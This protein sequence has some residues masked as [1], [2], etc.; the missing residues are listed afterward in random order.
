MVVVD[1]SSGAIP[2]G[3]CDFS[4]KLPPSC[5]CLRIFVSQSTF[6]FSF[7]LGL[8]TLRCGASPSMT[9]F[10][11]LLVGEKRRLLE[12]FMSGDRSKLAFT[13]SDNG[14]VR[15]CLIGEVGS[16]EVISVDSS[17]MICR[18]FVISRH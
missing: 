7:R 18:P 5:F 12:P 3:S 14:E 9:K 15:C 1:D 6:S 8:E 17:K 2:V 16:C 13:R 10:G 11:R 4:F